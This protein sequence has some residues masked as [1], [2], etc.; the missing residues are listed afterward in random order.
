[1]NQHE[2]LEAF[3]KITPY[4]NK[5]VHDD[6]T[7]GIANTEKIIM[8]I[9]GE[10]FDLNV[11]IARVFNNAT[12]RTYCSGVSKHTLVSSTSADC[13]EKSM[14]SCESSSLRRGDWEAKINRFVVSNCIV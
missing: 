11:R 7:I 8:N 9:P 1:M 6:V 14:P 2:V 12:S 5:L 13:T 10:T 4:F 3:V